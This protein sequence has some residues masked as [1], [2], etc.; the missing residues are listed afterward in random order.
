[1]LLKNVDGAMVPDKRF[2][3]VLSLVKNRS[4]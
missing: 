2:I 3:K 1:L 4:I